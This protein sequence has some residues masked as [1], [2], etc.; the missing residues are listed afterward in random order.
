MHKQLLKL[1]WLWLLPLIVSANFVNWLGDYDIA[2]QKALK[3][4]KPL[5]VLVVKR[6][7]TLSNKII[8]NSFMDQ[9]YVDMINEKT[10]A[11][12]VTYEGSKS[13]P[14][15]MYYTTV[16]PTLFFMDSE[17]ELFLREP[18]YGKEISSEKIQNYIENL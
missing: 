13:Y 17:R 16:F 10:V 4:R 14:I 12:I 5:L 8:K 2:H 3:E 6:N 11:V 9:P 7:S 18:L 15:E 1:L